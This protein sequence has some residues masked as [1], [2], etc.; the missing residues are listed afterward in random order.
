[1]DPLTQGLLGASL[2]Q[3]ASKRGQLVIAG[4]LGL[5]A[6]MAP[7]LDV[8]IRS[9]SDPLLVLE[10]HRQ[11]THS[12]LFIPIGSLI[13]TLVLHPLFAK[14]RGLTFKQSW[15]YCTLGYGTHALLD[16]C[17]SY[18]T[19]LFWPLS[20]LR[21]AWNTVSVIDPAFTL[22][23]LILVSFATLK[24]NPWYARI[25]FLWALVYLTLG[26][27]QRDKAEVAGWELAQERQH[28]PIRLAAKPTFANIL[29]WKIVYETEGHYHIDAVRVG[30]TVKSYPGESVA[31]LDVNRDFP[32]LDPKSQQAKDI[33]R[34]RWFSNGYVAQDPSDKLRIIDVRYS[35]VPNEV[36][37]LWS[38]Q[39][40]PIATAH[41]H[42]EYKTHRDNSS[43]SREA[44]LGMLTDFD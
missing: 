36:N 10:Y 42:A 34:F 7:D 39:L 6:G 5:F 31:K 43:E 33:E 27:I 13:C 14:R 35:V 25:A 19:Q 32:W 37:A 21:Y 1:M 24:R 41:A 8:L 17:T 15:F 11:F 28:T 23:I 2:P 29:V 4:V 30:A 20:N 22:P 18:G 40:S 16:A 9:S 26:M 38:I 44:F 12:L 3:S